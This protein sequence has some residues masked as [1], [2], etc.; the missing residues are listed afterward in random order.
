MED[1]L[2]NQGL[3]SRRRGEST[4][5]IL[6]QAGICDRR[7]YEYSSSFF[8][9]RL[10][11]TVRIFVRRN[12]AYS[13]LR[14]YLDNLRLEYLGKGHDICANTSYDETH[15]LDA[16]FRNVASCLDFDCANFKLQT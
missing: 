14:G 12:R 16:R 11:N 3:A 8:W 1:E 6:Q 15:W 13:L 2:T 10:A 4:M 5:L 9:S 7:L